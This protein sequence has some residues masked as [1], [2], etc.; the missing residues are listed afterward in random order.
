MFES[1]IKKALDDAERLNPIL[2]AFLSLE[3]AH[4]E[5]RIAELGKERQELPLFGYPIAVKDNIC[6][7]GLR[8]SCGSRILENYRAHYNA[9]AI[10][11]L[12]QAGAVV[13]GKTNMD[14]FAMGSSNENS[15][16]GICRN[17]WDTER[18]PGGSSG[19]SAA[20]V[21][22]GVVRASLGSETGGSVRQPASLCGVVGLKPTY[23]RISRYG[24][25][26]FASSLDNIGI[27]GRS[28][29]DA[30]KVLG[31]IAG[32][33]PL[34]STSAEVP[35]PDY[36]AT[37]DATVSGRRIGV[38]WAL[39]GEGLD[40]EVRSAVERSI[41]GFRSIG[42]EIVDI[43]LPHAMYGIAVY[44]IIATAEASSNL[45]RY[46]GVRYGF[47]AEQ[48]NSL[49]EMYHQTR[50]EGFGP[51]VKRRIMLGTY[52]LSSGYYDAYYAKAQ[53]VRALVKRDY[54][55][56]FAS[57]DAILTPTSP[58]TAFRIGERS[59][60]PLAM[61][62]SD[63]YTVSANLAGIPAISVPCGLSSENLPIGLQLLGNFW[64][65]A[66]LLNMAYKFESEFPLKEMPKI[67]AD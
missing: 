61:Y 53:K 37:L 41:E 11:K 62:L 5:E 29:R 57:C 59:D 56:A 47:R 19:G 4:A 8:T 6:T 66:L 58:T 63:I 48:A 39:M 46:D 64:S 17:P 65:E 44:Y 23:G 32:R 31:V 2:N 36:E 15:A 51:E 28:V 27:F 13:I 50:E 34:D 38:P 55:R 54:E 42:A 43:E 67:F 16:F 3:Q 24:L 9:T 49:R 26:A 22:S 12:N 20:A 33:D 7:Q 30:A 25:V 35:V 52:V 14:E 1:I 18:V 40:G 21:A 10:E 45:A 60:D